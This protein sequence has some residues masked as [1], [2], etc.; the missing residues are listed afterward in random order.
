MHQTS[1]DLDAYLR[2]IGYRGEGRPGPDE[3]S[4]RAIHALHVAAIPFEN[5]SP[6][7]GDEVSLDLG[8]L[9]DKLLARGRGGWCFEHNLLLQQALQAIGFS[10]R[11]VA[12]RVRWNVPA[13]VVNPRT[14]MLLLVG[15]DGAY[16]FAHARSGGITLSAPLRLQA[17]QPQETPHGRFRI[18]PEGDAFLLQAELPEGWRTLYA[19]DL[20]PQLLPDFELAN[21]YLSHHPRSPFVSNLMAARAEP[22][23]RHALFNNRY[24]LHHA[25]GS[26]T[27]V[28]E[29][30]DELR[31]LLTEAFGIRLPSHPALD[32][33]LQQL[34][35]APRHEPTRKESP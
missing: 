17:H 30:P 31:Q 34:T 8:A 7:L 22:G 21:W 10:V 24:T 4:L 25:G 29:Q 16:W 15:L 35:G 28:L 19:F 23:R 3:C 5:L 13:G 11:A 20:Q 18:A 27:R 26:E 6:L 12:A 1:P 9:Q 33:R 2:R 14:H 32:A